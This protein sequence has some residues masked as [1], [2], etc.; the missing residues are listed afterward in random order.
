[1]DATNLYISFIYVILQC[2]TQYLVHATD[3]YGRH[4]IDQRT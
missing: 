3:S 2:K 4:H 1:M